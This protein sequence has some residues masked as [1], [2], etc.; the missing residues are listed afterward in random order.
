MTESSLKKELSNLQR[1]KLSEKLQ[2]EKRLDQLKKEKLFTKQVSLR[3]RKIDHDEQLQ[4]LCQMRVQ[5][6]QKRKDLVLTSQ[7][8]VK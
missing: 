6:E 5:S 1:D 4:Q 3:Q 8:E 7:A 2:I